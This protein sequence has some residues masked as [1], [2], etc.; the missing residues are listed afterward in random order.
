[1]LGRPRSGGEGASS[2]RED[3]RAAGKQVVAIDYT[4]PTAVDGNGSL[5]LAPGLPFVGNDRW[6]SGGTCGR[7]PSADCM[8]CATMCKQI[9]ALQTCLE[10]MSQ[11]FR[12]GGYDLQVAESHQAHKADTSGT[13]MEMVKYFGALTGAPFPWIR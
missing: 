9:V 2:G 10:M 7:M 11:Q 6:R 13:A 5:Y 1:M 4:H 3:T 8:R 12:F